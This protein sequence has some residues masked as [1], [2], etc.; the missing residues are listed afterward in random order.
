MEKLS[1]ED[2]ADM[3]TTANLFK[4]AAELEVNDYFANKRY[5][6]LR[7]IQDNPRQNPAKIA[8]LK[9][10]FDV[11]NVATIAGK[12][13]QRRMEAEIETERLRLA[14]TTEDPGDAQPGV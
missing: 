9:L 13:A 12:E 14:H 1:P 5:G 11:Y 7:D 6:Q 2:R 3:E 4:S 10:E 8:G